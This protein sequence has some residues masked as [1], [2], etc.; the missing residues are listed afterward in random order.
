[1]LLSIPFVSIY[2]LIHNKNSR[3]KLAL[4]HQ[5]GNPHTKSEYPCPSYNENCIVYTQSSCIFLNTYKL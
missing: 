1:M 2:T 5:L 3:K 4:Y